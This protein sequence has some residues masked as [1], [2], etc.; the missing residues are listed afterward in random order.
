MMIDA[1]VLNAQ[2]ALQVLGISRATL[3]RLMRRG[4]IEPLERPTAAKQVVRLRFRRS[5]VER[6]AQP[7]ARAG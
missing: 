7:V 3:N 6:L 2:Q 4:V 5:D 1:P